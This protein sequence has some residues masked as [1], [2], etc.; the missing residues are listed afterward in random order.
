MPGSPPPPGSSAPTP[1]SPADPQ[2]GS[3][4]LHPAGARCHLSAPWS[5]R[6]AKPWGSGNPPRDGRG[7]AAACRRCGE[8]PVVPPRPDVGL[9]GEGAAVPPA[10]PTRPAFGWLGSPPLFLP[11]PSSRCSA[12]GNEEQS[13]LSPSPPLPAQLGGSAKLLAPSGLA[14]LGVSQ[15][16]HP[17]CAAPGA[18]EEQRKQDEPCRV[19]TNAFAPQLPGHRALKDS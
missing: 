9:R 3:V 2:P 6:P 5:Q 11:L 19:V 12:R 13:L 10:P 15:A 16:F 14:S 1:E 8:R 17:Q 4:L 18:L 7:E